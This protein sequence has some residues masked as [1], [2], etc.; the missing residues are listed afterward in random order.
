MCQFGRQERACG[1]VG[2]ARDCFGYGRVSF[3]EWGMDPMLV[4]VGLVALA[5]AGLSVWLGLDRAKKVANLTHATNELAN[6]GQTI[7]AKDNDLVERATQL[8]DAERALADANQELKTSQAEHRAELLRINDIGAEKL[9]SAK[10][11]RAQLESRVREMDEQLTQRF[12]A[13]ANEVVRGTNKFLLEHNKREL[14]ARAQIADS[15]LEKREKAVQQLVNPLNDLLRQTQERL[16]A[17]NEARIKNESQIAQQFLDITSATRELR[18]ETGKF[19]RAMSRPEVRG[20]YGEIQL[21]RI[22]ELAGMVANC[23]FEEQHT[24]TDDMG[25]AKRPDMV[26]RLPNE[27][28]IAVDSKANLGAYL[29]ALQADTPELQEQHMQ[30]FAR[31]MVEQVRA[32]SAKAYWSDLRGSPDFVVM[33]VPGDQF[34]DAALSRQ[35]DLLD[36]AAQQNVILASP[37]T[38]IGLLRAVAV[39][40]REQSL[41]EEARQLFEL[42]HELHERTAN[43][44][45]AAN[46]C[47]KSLD[48]AV[49]QYNKFARSIESRLMPTLRRFEAVGVKSA[50]ELVEPPEIEIRA[51]RFA[52]PESTATSTQPMLHDTNDED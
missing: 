8:R 10:R 41:A 15:E 51:Q 42:G 1:F 28:M 25:R 23:D 47:G 48:D 36:R 29:E 44:L 49:K 45:D 43:V 34:L 20:R 14:D 19:A 12:Q 4:I 21:R 17:L 46:K 5:L 35:P 27:R 31:H 52:L 40:W 6:A 3:V 24:T 30:R 50:K 37:A 32:L 26:V 39:G 33:F 13:V 2:W 9:E 18:D 7:R 16:A 11:E 38:L 22:A